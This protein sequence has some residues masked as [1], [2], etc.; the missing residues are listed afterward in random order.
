MTRGE[1]TFPVTVLEGKYEKGYH[2]LDGLF[3][4]SNE[5]DLFIYK[6]VGLHVG[7]YQATVYYEGLLDELDGA[8]N[9]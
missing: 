2:E 4:M 6:A 9:D 7:E 3:E 8:V 1:L 5:D